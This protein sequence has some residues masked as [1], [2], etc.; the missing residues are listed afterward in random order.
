[1]RKVV[2]PAALC[3]L[4]L[5]AACSSSN[6]NKNRPAPLTTI[7]GTPAASV[8]TPGT[9]SG[10]TPAA[11][12]SNGTPFP[13][14]AAGTPLATASPASAEASAT[15][16][17]SAAAATP[18]A[19]TVAPAA[20]ASQTA[21]T[22]TVAPSAGATSAATPAPAT[23]ATAAPSAAS[24]AGSSAS[25]SDLID[26]ITLTAADLPSGFG[27]GGLSGHQSNQQA[28]TGYADPQA[29]LKL[30]NDTGRQDGYIQQITSPD[31]GSGI[32]VSIEVWG[33][34]AGAKAFFDQYPSPPA[35]VKA[36]PFTLPQPLGDQSYAYQYALGAGSG[37]SIAWRRGRVVL[38][39]GEP[40]SGQAALDHL[41]QIAAILDAKA[42]AA[43]Q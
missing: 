8:R 11:A 5:C 25:A 31:S 3:A 23:A 10:A 29:V 13:S 24:G 19:T 21:P 6:N 42:Q 30:F 17:S 36:Q 16:T 28:I 38:G 32:G 12:I 1:L 34:A 40:A 9:P 26:Q 20:T 41:L 7:A 35:E 15:P 27:V 4:T 18:G 43:Q 14:V 22:A 2:L 33:D 39:V 37:T